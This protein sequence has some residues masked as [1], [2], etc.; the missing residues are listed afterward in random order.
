MDL[1]A[2]NGRIERRCTQVE[3][4]RRARSNQYDT[5]SHVLPRHLPGEN[6][7]RGNIG[8]RV[9]GTKFQDS[10]AIGVGR[11]FKIADFEVIEPGVSAESR[12]TAGVGGFQN[13][14]ARPLCNAQHF[15]GQRRPQLIADAIQ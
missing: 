6:L 2:R 15:G 7:P 12:L 11:D 3:Q 14:G 8:R 10:P 5:P 13:I 4:A 9:L 1:D